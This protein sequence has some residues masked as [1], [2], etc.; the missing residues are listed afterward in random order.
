MIISIKH[1][2]FSKKHFTI[3]QHIFRFALGFKR[4][5]Y[6][7]G[8]RQP[9]DRFQTLQR[10]KNMLLCV[11]WSLSERH[12]CAEDESQRFPAGD[13]LYRVYYTTTGHI[14]M[15]VILKFLFLFF[16]CRNVPSLF[17]AYVFIV[18][19]SWTLCLIS[20]S[21]RFNII[22]CRHNIMLSVTFE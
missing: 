5:T 4:L 14:D 9:D 20:T 11:L 6:N 17:R 22:T 7:S 2:F 13:R 10:R 19:F 12:F 8:P 21:S 15:A 3:N 18:L 1:F 16:F